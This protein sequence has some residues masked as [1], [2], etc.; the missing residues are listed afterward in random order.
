[1]K[2][3]ITLIISLLCIMS[4]M[5]A[6]VACDGKDNSGENG[7]GQPSGSIGSGEDGNGVNEVQHF[8][9]VMT[10][11]LNE[12]SSRLT[13]SVALTSALSE[14]LGSGDSNGFEK[15]AALKEIYDYMNTVEG[16][17]VIEEKI[18]DE[19]A[20]RNFLS[21]RAYGELVN[22]ICE[23]DKIYAKPIKINRKENVSPSTS[24]A[25]I[26]SEGTH[27]IVY[28]YGSDGEV[29]ESVYKWDI[30]YISDK[31]FSAKMLTISDG[32]P[33]YYIY[34]DTDGESLSIMCN[35]SSDD[36]GV[37]Q[38]KTSN[39]DDSYSSSDSNAVKQCLAKVQ[40]EFDSIDFKYLR[41]L[42]DA[43]QNTA[44]QQQYDDIAD[45]LCKEYG[46]A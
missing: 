19:F 41:S 30:N 31:E 28:L 12:Y 44:E 6:L 17:E 37:I 40:Y 27:I 2:K 5:I 8:R 1:M 15:S 42:K 11:V 29:G 32:K 10:A 34:G 38:Y 36:G 22:Q 3:K 7:S 25:V 20:I 39:S 26:L 35:S 14:E 24:Y 46:L 33:T 13:S 18:I 23:T 4:I 45:A 21:A 43:Y 16:K 9:R